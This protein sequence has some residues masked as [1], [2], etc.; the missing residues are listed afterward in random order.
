[1]YMY[2]LLAGFPILLPLGGYKIP[3][4][5]IHINI[6]IHKSVSTH[7]SVMWQQSQL[8]RRDKEIILI[9]TWKKIYHFPLIII[10]SNN[11]QNHCYFCGIRL[12]KMWE[13]QLMPNKYAFLY[14]QVP[15]TNNLLCGV[16]YILSCPIYTVLALLFRGLILHFFHIFILEW[17]QFMKKYKPFSN[18]FI[19][20]CRKNKS[21]FNNALPI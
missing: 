11:N 3:Q 7:T 4:T 1:M 13:K 14:S 9:L 5:I 21:G 18:S 20:S 15:G 12:G 2:I 17:L 6:K 16:L 8:Q 10:N 19:E